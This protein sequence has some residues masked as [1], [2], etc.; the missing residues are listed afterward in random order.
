MVNCR[1]Q[2]PDK[3]APIQVAQQ[4]AHEVPDRR[5]AEIGRDEAYPDGLASVARARCQDRRGLGRVTLVPAAT[6]LQKFFGTHRGAILLVHEPVAIGLGIA[7]IPS[8][9]LLI[10]LDAGI[11]VALLDLD[12]AHIVPDRGHRRVA[13]EGRLEFLLRLLEPLELVKADA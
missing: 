8:D 11:G 13:L 1:Q 9:R 2:V 4:S 3:L 5:P 12:R 7:G 10:G 6:Q